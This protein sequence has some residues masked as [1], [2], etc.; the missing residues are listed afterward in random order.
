MC[1]SQSKKSDKNIS[2]SMKA[3]DAPRM[4]FDNAAVTRTTGNS[5]RTMCAT[6]LAL[7]ELLLLL[8]LSTVMM[9]TNDYTTTLSSQTLSEGCHMKP[10]WKRVT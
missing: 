7:L 5:M 6:M 9:A 1:S 8:M 2:K 10:S 4:V 3:S